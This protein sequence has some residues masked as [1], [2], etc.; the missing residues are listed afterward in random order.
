MADEQSRLC[1]LKAGSGSRV[2]C[3]CRQCL[4]R[5]LASHLH[6]GFLHRLPPIS[7]LTG[8]L[9]LGHDNNRV[10]VF[11]ASI[12]LHD[13]ILTIIQLNLFDCFGH[14]PL[15]LPREGVDVLAWPHK[16]LQGEC[17]SYFAAT[18][19]STSPNIRHLSPVGHTI[20]P[21]STIP[22]SSILLLLF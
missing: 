8:H 11:D 4:V 1:L 7:F 2:N 20:P 12:H 9:G 16:Q 21:K 10:R 18:S 6:L 19:T 3:G 22:D 13:V 17:F 5:F 14:S 15:C